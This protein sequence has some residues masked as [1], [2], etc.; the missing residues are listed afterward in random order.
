VATDGIDRYYSVL[1]E[2]NERYAD[3]SAP[4][5]DRWAR[6]IFPGAST[7]Q[8]FDFRGPEM[9]QR[10]FRQKEHDW[11]KFGYTQEFLDSMRSQS[12]WD[13]Q[14]ARVH[15]YDQKICARRPGAAQHSFTE[16]SACSSSR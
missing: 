2:M 8:V 4:V 9:K 6:D 12:F 7:E 13:A 3:L 16:Q 10:L 1:E 11:L 5:L 14:Y 15:E